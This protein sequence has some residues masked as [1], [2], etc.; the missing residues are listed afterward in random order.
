MVASWAQSW[1]SNDVAGYLAAYAPDFKVPA[2]MSRGAW[3]AQRKQR[4]AKPRQIQ[5]EI[6]NPKVTLSG[7]STAT[8]VFR[9]R[10]KSGN[11]DTTDTKTLAVRRVDG[12]WK[13]VEEATAN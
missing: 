1:A 8:V 7:D 2:G 5:V 13:I 3:E 9:Q 11:I 4:I 6:D 10:Y 12:A